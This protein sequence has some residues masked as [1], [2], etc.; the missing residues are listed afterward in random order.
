M[1]KHRGMS[2]LSPILVF[3]VTPSRTSIIVAY[4]VPE[5]RQIMTHACNT[6]LFSADLV[7]RIFTQVTGDLGFSVYSTQGVLNLQLLGK[8]DKQAR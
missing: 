6:N 4:R 5:V 2:E 7:V 1:L 8:V 3:P